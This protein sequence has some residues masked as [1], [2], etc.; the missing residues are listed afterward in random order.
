MSREQHV[1][2]GGTKKRVGAA[3]LSLGKRVALGDQRFRLVY[4]GERSA[5]VD[6]AGR[7]LL[8]NG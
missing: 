8:E 1:E 4:D 7:K 3:A 6:A 5:D 2:C